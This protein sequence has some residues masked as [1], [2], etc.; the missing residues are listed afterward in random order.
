MFVSSGVINFRA[1]NLV[2]IEFGM[3]A[4]PVSSL[5]LQLG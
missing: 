2:G 1:I 4:L 5:F 3:I